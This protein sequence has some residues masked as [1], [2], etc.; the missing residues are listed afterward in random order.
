MSLCCEVGRCSASGTGLITLGREVNYFQYLTEMLHLCGY[1]PV[2]YMNT[3]GNCPE[4]FNIVY[5]GITRTLFNYIEV[6]YT[7]REGERRGQ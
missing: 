5:V 1:I 7:E 4:K 3:I 2:K 6:D